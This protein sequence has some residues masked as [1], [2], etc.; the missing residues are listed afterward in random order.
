[1]SHL[2]MSSTLAM[3]SPVGVIAPVLAQAAARY[4][5]VEPVLV[6][7]GEAVALGIVEMHERLIHG[8]RP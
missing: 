1:M 4:W 2:D 5:P 8:E 3:I 6:A 7:G